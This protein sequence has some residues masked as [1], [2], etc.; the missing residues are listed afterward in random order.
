MLLCGCVDTEE[1]AAK[2]VCRREVAVDQ[3]ELHLHAHGFNFWE[4]G[5]GV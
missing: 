2:P 5:H 1:V 4:W 3:R